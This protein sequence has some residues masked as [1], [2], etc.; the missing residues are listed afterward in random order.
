MKA[1]RIVAVVLCCSFGL[2]STAWA[3]EQAPKP[4]GADLSANRGGDDRDTREMVEMILAAKLAKELELN[5]EQTVL[6]LRR[7]SEFR[8]Q[9]SASRKQRQEILKALK[10]GVKAGEPDAQIEAKLNELV[11]QDVKMAEFR[12][13]AYEKACEGL[14]IAQRAKLYVFLNEFENDMRKLVQQARERNAHRLGRAME[15]SRPLEGSPARPPRGPEPAAR[16]PR[17]PR[18]PRQAPTE[19]APAP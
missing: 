1:M 2:V 3:Q 11:V 4:A 18:P 12:K 10:A 9:V 17:P 15:P 7:L 16:P 13:T 8:E 6:M 19:P 14:S 5:D